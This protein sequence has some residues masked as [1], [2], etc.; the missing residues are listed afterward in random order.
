MHRRFVGDCKRPHGLFGAII[1]N[2]SFAT[3]R[4]RFAN[5]VADVVG[6]VEAVALRLTRKWRCDGFPILERRTDHQH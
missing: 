5:E 6:N 1:R 3:A 2:A 4:Q